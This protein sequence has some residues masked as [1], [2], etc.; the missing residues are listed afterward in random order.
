MKEEKFKI[1]LDEDEKVLWCD[2]V[3][4]SAFVKKCFTKL[5]LFGLFPPCALLMLG[6]PYGWLLLLLSL[7][8]VIPMLI[9]VIHFSFSIVVCLVYIIILNK[10]AKNTFCCITNKRVIKRSGAFTNDFKHYS[11]KNIGNVQVDGSIFDSKGDNPSAN[12]LI[13][14]KDYHTNTDGN[15][16]P[17]VLTLESLNNAYEAYKIINELTEGNNESFRVKVE[18]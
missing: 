10:R 17:M 5:F 6:V 8:N 18:K 9:G 4:K 7:L 3:N 12:L 15:S 1:V 13:T 11:L 16:I 14:V 2:G